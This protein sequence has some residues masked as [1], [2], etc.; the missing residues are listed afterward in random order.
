M[1][2]SV[3]PFHG[4]YEILSKSVNAAMLKTIQE[5]VRAS[6]AKVSEEEAV[7]LWPRIK[8]FRNEHQREPSLNS[9]DPIEVRYAETLAFIRQMKQQRMAKQQQMKDQQENAH[10]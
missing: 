4:A 5:T 9:S 1:I 8:A 6:Q 7:M 2:D 3:N 10:A